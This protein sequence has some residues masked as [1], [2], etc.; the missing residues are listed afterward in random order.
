MTGTPTSA[1]R[2]GPRERLLA[3][4]A[5]LTY[6]Q[7]IHVG[8]DAI[9]KEA[10]VARRSLYQ[11]F[12][13]KDGLIAEVLRTQDGLARYHEAMDA[14]G[15]D[16]R[17]RILAVFTAWEART[18]AAD[19]HGCRYT[20]AEVTLTD[21]AHPAHA[22]VRAFKQGL[23]DLFAAELTRAGHPAPELAADQL[24]VLVDGTA[25]HALTRPEAHPA[26]A[27]RSL[28]ELIL[29]QADA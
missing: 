20:A 29:A 12:G 8:V 2:P 11:H 5:D 19:Y 22:E 9:L 17:E 27:A 21:P 3:A 28:A 10:D 6:R 7:G 4:A 15:D 13:G 1:T 16:P 25:A 26:L 24:A 14:A 18:T 23:H